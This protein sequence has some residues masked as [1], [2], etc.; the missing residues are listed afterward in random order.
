MGRVRIPYYVVIKG[1]GYWRPTPA[2]RAKGFALVRCGADGP[3]AWTIAAAWNER[4]Q[5]CRRGE[6]PLAADVSRVSP[7]TAEAA[8]S[9]PRGSLG[10]AFTEYRATGEW[11]GKAART[12]EDWWRGW[13]RIRPVFGDVD[14]RTVGLAEISAWRALIEEQSG[15]REAHRAL[16]IWRAL[17]KVA[18][19]LRYCRRD[20]DP[21]LEV[22]N[23]AAA[24][25]A[26][27]W[28]E[29]EIARL[30]KAAWRSG[31]QG[32]AVS[33]A[34]MWDSQWSSVDVRTLAMQRIER[35]PDGVVIRGTRGKTRVPIAAVLSRRTMRL[36]DAYLASMGA[37]PVGEAPVLR[38][39]GAAAGPQGGRP[40]APRP[41]TKDT[42]TAEFRVVR[43][44]VFGAHET[45]QLLDIRRS[46]AIEAIAGD[47][48]R[49][50][51]GHAMGNSIAAST[52]LF[53]TYVPVSVTSLNDVAA[54]RRRGREKLRSG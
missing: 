23:H 21:S 39:R 15:R 51:L 7:E 27:S 17:W 12:R 25:R 34:I 46:G 32:L 3:D 48:T 47:A 19:A 36:L 53:K 11:R 22:R 4:W 1:R 29:G 5:R 10:A 37:E 40:W 50:K 9:Y 54:A 44:A 33:V 49:E 16:K 38:T 26:A 20:D 35:R 13:K 14:P 28:S 31:H 18:A 45:R 42:L 24:P 6:A 52:G 30:V 41:F 43:A 2:M 8:I